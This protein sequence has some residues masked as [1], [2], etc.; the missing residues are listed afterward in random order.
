[1]EEFILGKVCHDD[2]D[3][4]VHGRQFMGQWI[5]EEKARILAELAIIKLQNAQIATK[6]EPNKNL[7]KMHNL[8]S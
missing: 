6:E 2:F 1:M 5:Y 4:P 3:F 8:Q 7:I